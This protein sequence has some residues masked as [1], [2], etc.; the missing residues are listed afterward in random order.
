[1][2]QGISASLRSLGVVCWDPTKRQKKWRNLGQ[3]DEQI[4]NNLPAMPLSK[5]EQEERTFPGFIWILYIS[6]YH[7]SN[8]Q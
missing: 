5:E 4:W 6:L 2:R 3:M 8:I 1:L 7:T